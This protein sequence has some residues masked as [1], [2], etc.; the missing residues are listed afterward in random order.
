MR[1]DGSVMRKNIHLSSSVFFYLRIIYNMSAQQIVM[2][3][4]KYI[5][6]RVA[7]FNEKENLKK[8]LKK[9]KEQSKVH[10]AKKI[11]ALEKKGKKVDAK[12]VDGLYEELSA[13]ENTIVNEKGKFD[14][15]IYNPEQIEQMIEQE[16]NS[17][18]S[19]IDN[20]SE[21]AEFVPTDF[22]TGIPEPPYV[23]PPEIVPLSE[24]ELKIMELYDRASRMYVML[25]RKSHIAFLYNEHVA[26]LTKLRNE[27]I[28]HRTSLIGLT[29][30]VVIARSAPLLAVIR[31]MGDLN[32]PA[33]AFVTEIAA[34]EAEVKNLEVVYNATYALYEKI[35]KISPN[36]EIKTDEANF[37]AEETKFNNMI[38]AT[39]I[40]LP[41]LVDSEAKCDAFVAQAEVEYVAYEAILGA[42]GIDDIVAVTCTLPWQMQHVENKDIK[43][44]IKSL[45][46]KMSTLDETNVKK[47]AFNRAARKLK[48]QYKQKIKSE[49][50][51]IAKCTMQNRI[52][53]EEGS[54]TVSATKTANNCMANIL[55]SISNQGP[56]IIGF[57][58]YVPDRDADVGI[59]PMTGNYNEDDAAHGGISKGGVDYKYFDTTVRYPEKKH[60]MATVNYW[61][62]AIPGAI[63]GY[64]PYDIATDT[65][66]H[67]STYN[68]DDFKR[69][70]HPYIRGD[71]PSIEYIISGVEKKN[72]ALNKD[73]I[74]HIIARINNN[75]DYP[76]VMTVWNNEKLGRPIY[77]IGDSLEPNGKDSPIC[78]IVTDRRFLIMNFKM[79]TQIS[80]DGKTIPSADGTMGVRHEHAYGRIAA[81]MVIVNANVDGK[82]YDPNRIIVLG[83]FNVVGP[84]FPNNGIIPGNIKLG[85]DNA[86]NAITLKKNGSIKSCCYYP[87][88]VIRNKEKEGFKYEN[89]MIFT[90]GEMSA[91]SIVTKVENV[92]MGVY[93]PVKSTLNFK[94]IMGGGTK[95]ITSGGIGMTGGIVGG[96][97]ACIG[98]GC[99]IAMFI[100]C[101]LFLAYMYCIVEDANRKKEVQPHNINVDH[102]HD[103]SVEG[104][105]FV[106]DHRILA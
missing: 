90:S 54:M 102:F 68:V 31:N 70:W 23:P 39:V 88:S 29:H 71:V 80:S 82:N 51:R 74:S 47:K 21:Q 1:M 10:I 16:V 73:K 55:R 64:A 46:D 40:P 96:A 56:D 67:M 7:E 99:T 11:E 19:R 103:H 79:P 91:P 97:I 8:K 15:Q 87:R 53:K 65:K 34:Y 32:D 84:G 41:A 89:D 14:V 92:G 9:L 5:G 57:Q 66:T 50:F 72:P 58:N 18:I 38:D 75:T 20:I 69:I 77:V 26:K 17:Y 63:P 104:P 100:I 22:D 105:R 101:I 86:G 106:P 60:V 45:T 76:S 83:S 6:E 42:L 85:V 36:D 13:L 62:P 52:A 98:G 35:S 25:S 12:V 95:A 28:A 2:D 48:K 44:G 81:L 78:I 27:A 94:G 33:K 93:K 30:S 24:R 4:D 61:N 43:V 49:P 59:D 3:D 37:A